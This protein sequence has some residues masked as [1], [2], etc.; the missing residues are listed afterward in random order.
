MLVKKTMDRRIL[1][2]HFHSNPGRDNQRFNHAFS[3]PSN[4]PSPWCLDE[5]SRPSTK[6][7]ECLHIH[8][9]PLAVEL[10]PQVELMA[11]TIA[12]SWA[13]ILVVFALMR[14]P[15]L[16]AVVQSK[17]ASPRISNFASGRVAI[18]PELQ[19]FGGADLDLVVGVGSCDVCPVPVFTHRLG[20]YRV[21]DEVDLV[22]V[23]A[24]ART[25]SIR[26]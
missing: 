7:P 18:D 25:E 24:C 12:L 21:V 9:S 20:R 22:L 17:G 1:A 13:L 14:V 8:L 15:M 19:T 23:G 11:V 16:R 6:H 26:S 5:S 3:S 4:S 2:E 10:T